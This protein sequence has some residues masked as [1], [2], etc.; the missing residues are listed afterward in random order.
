MT[1][2]TTRS[3]LALLATNRRYLLFTLVV[4]MPAVAFGALT[5]ARAALAMSAFGG[6]VGLGSI[7]VVISLAAG[8]AAIPS[9]AISDAFGPRTVFLVSGLA[10]A[11]VNA[12]TAWMA[13]TGQLTALNFMVL[14]GVDGAFAAMNATSFVPMQVSLVEPRDRGSAQIVHVL[15]LSLG[16]LIGTFIAGVV[17][18]PAAVAFAAS[19]IVAVFNLIAWR[20]A[21]PSRTHDKSRTRSTV[22]IDLRGLL[23][24]VRGNRPLAYLITLLVVLTFVIPTQLV[25]LVLADNG[26]LRYGYQASM[27]GLLGFLAARLVLMATGLRLP[28]RG[29]MLITMSI[30][31]GVTLVGAVL[32]Y[33][34]LLLGNIPLVLALVFIASLASGIALEFNSALVQQLCPDAIRGRITGLITSGRAIMTAIGAFVAT[35]IQLALDEPELVGTLTVLGILVL[36]LT[37]GFARIPNPDRMPS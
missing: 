9:G 20:I 35:T 23:A 24:T 34:D 32:L 28:P 31:T 21:R 1:P 37:R 16:A 17:A 6:A 5:T 27:A 22:R 10:S 7:A 8:A 18:A 15:R 25:G 33:A 11:T 3:P 4:L 30:Y 29:T 19:L 13:V 26:L 2:H 12:V 14:A 36:V